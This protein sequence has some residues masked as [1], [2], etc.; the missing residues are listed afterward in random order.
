MPRTAA[1]ISSVHST[2]RST[3]V[4]DRSRR[5]VEICRG[6]R[7]IDLGFVDEG[8][9]TLRQL[10]GT[11]L[12]AALA[13]SARE[14]VGLDA[15]E[16]GVEQ[17]RELGFAAISVDCTNAELVGQLALEPADVVVA[18]EL[19]EHLDSPGDLLEAAKRLLLPDGTLV[20]TTPNGLSLTNFLA[21]LGRRELVNVDHVA[22]Y[23]RRTL[24]TLLERHGWAIEELSFYRF[25]RV[26]GAEATLARGTPIAARAFDAYQ[27]AARPFF[28]VLPNLADGL[29]VV[30]RLEDP[31]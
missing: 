11:W 30:A 15:D 16:L 4:V 6:K 28:N 20:L 13:E 12:H 24:S 9:M 21:G 18:G 10:Q 27:L 29:L 8:R 5:L 14:I 7:V 31:A 17:A 23:S 3:K 1:S 19:I 25:P 22:W 26:A 2:P